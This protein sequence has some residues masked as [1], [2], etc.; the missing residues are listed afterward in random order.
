MLKGINRNVM[1]V[2]PHSN[3]PFEAVYFVI[4]KDKG[5]YKT[6]MIKEANRIICEG[7]A[8]RKPRHRKL[9]LTLLFICAILLGAAAAV[10]ICLLTLL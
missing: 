4:K 8:P 3:S 5:I 10:V 6:D 7:A 9:K 1:V 2:R